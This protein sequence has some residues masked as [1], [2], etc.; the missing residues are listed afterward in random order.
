MSSGETRW[1][2]GRGGSVGHE[3]L[4]SCSKSTQDQSRTAP[5]ACPVADCREKETEEKG[6]GVPTHSLDTVVEAPDRALVLVRL[7]LVAERKREDDTRLLKE[8]RPERAKVVHRGAG[9]CWREVF[10]R[11]G[12]TVPRTGSI[13]STPPDDILRYLNPSLNSIHARSLPQSWTSAQS[14]T[15]FLS[16]TLSSISFRS[17]FVF[18]PVAC[19][20]PFRSTS[21]ASLRTL[22]HNVRIPSNCSS[23]HQLTRST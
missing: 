22:P 9:E 10:C 3:L 12:V 19:F 16:R 17:A 2:R 11:I 21:C 5:H 23:Q 6:R 14:G 7:D 8:R 13:Q 20:Q 1:R 15:L 18:S 4:R